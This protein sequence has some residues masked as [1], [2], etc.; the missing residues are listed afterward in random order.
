MS[1]SYP[2]WKTFF[3]FF[4]LKT[5][6]T[7]PFGSLL[8]KLKPKTGLNIL[9]Y[10]HSVRHLFSFVS[11][12]L[13]LS[14]SYHSNGKGK[15]KK[16]G[17]KKYGRDFP[18]SWNALSVTLDVSFL[19]VFISVSLETQEENFLKWEEPLGSQPH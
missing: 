14:K 4:L 19:L 5:L 3:F 18:P 16:K 6:S 17:K 8:T 15:K 7:L 11:P 13:W 12:K 1:A 10:V 9:F 2:T